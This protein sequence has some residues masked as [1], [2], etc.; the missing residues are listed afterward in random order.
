[1]KVPCGSLRCPRRSPRW[2]E[3]SHGSI[4]N[5]NYAPNRLSS[6]WKT[7][8]AYRDSQIEAF[9]DEV[10]DLSRSTWLEF[11]ERCAAT[12]S[13]DMATFPK[14]GQFIVKLSENQ[15][16]VAKFL[17]ANG[18][19]DLL[20]FLPGFLNGLIKSGDHAA[21]KQSLDEFLARPGHLLSIAV[22]WRGSSPNDPETLKV[23]L[24]RAIEDD[25]RHAIAE[26][27]LFAM[28]N[29]P[30]NVPSNDELVRPALRHLIA[31]KD[32]RWINLAWLPEKTPFF[33][34]FEAIDASLILESLV[35]FPE[36]PWNGERILSFV[37]EPY[38]E[39]VWDFLG[40]RLQHPSEGGDDVRYE[41][42][43]HRFQLLAAS[44]SSDARLAVAKARGWFEE[45][46]S[47][48][49]YRGGRV[50]ASIFSGC[51]PE[52]AAALV[53][54]IDA[55]TV[56]DAKFILSVMQNYHGETST[57]SVLKA[58]LLKLPDDEGV[59]AGVSRSL[60]NTGVVHGEF[61]FVESLRMKKALIEPWLEDGDVRI[62]GFARRQI[63]DIDR[64]IQSEKRRADA[65]SA[66]RKLEFDN[67]DDDA[68]GNRE[69]G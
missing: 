9:L 59:R 22:H 17:L 69:G 2:G 32:A 40:R 51:P 18:N 48:F 16:S 57:H 47:L 31:V 34:T 23:L 54:L 12:R 56:K 14:L 20:R 52:F 15:P 25:D 65:Q 44:L 64:R 50:L 37:A 66:L 35:E 29:Y 8:D 60:E 67:L 38:L 5:G 45:D 53:A 1:L 11:L 10:D 62:S 49:G 41:A 30:E 61:G 58:L 46:S 27:L 55:G 43:P 4:L 7:T 42:V 26:C 21:Y 33:E 3:G 68:D 63:A 13:D 36:I 39:L 24:N 19:D 28:R 6:A